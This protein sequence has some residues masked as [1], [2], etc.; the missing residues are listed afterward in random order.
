M[1]YLFNF[2]Y[3]PVELDPEVMCQMA[4]ENPQEL[5]NYSVSGTRIITDYLE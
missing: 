1:F 5:A 3:D 2:R 4:R